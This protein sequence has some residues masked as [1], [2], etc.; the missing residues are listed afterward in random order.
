MYINYEIRSFN[1]L[2]NANSLSSKC[3]QCFQLYLKCHQ[4][5]TAQNSQKKVRC[6]HW[7]YLLHYTRILTVHAF[8]CGS[9]S[10][11]CCSSISAT[12]TLSSCAHRCI[13]VSQFFALLLAFAPLLSNRVA[14]Y[15]L[16]TGDVTCSGVY[17]FYSTDIYKSIIF[18]V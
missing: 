3:V 8:V 12:L 5:K 4:K 16:P 11:P 18:K 10:A 6:E 17:P 7:R 1:G 14:M 13:G 2:P 9:I 15:V